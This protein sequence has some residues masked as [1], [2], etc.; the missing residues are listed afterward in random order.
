[1]IDNLLVYY[2]I[3]KY[4]YSRLTESNDNKSFCFK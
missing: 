4:I 2:I 3:T 1:M